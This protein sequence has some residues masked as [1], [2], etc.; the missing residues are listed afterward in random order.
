MFVVMHV[1]IC[2]CRYN[3]CMYLCDSAAR[4][5]TPSRTLYT[6]IDMHV[7]RL[8]VYAYMSVCFYVCNWWCICMHACRY[9][10][11][12]VCIY[13]VTL[14]CVISLCFISALSLWSN[15]VMFFY[16]LNSLLHNFVMFLSRFFSLW[17]HFVMFYL[18]SFSL[19]QFS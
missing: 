5:D 6:C 14:S 12:H 3:V 15:F 11:L 2:I 1:C 19:V 18:L 17:C 9:V 10:G 4:P 13:A 7:C 16:R 8:G